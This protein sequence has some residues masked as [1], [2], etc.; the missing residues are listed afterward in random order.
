MAL[1]DYD[2]TR[3]HVGIGDAVDAKK[4]FLI[5]GDYREMLQNSPRV[6]SFGSQQ[7][8]FDA[9]SLSR[10]TQDDFLGGCYWPDWTAEDN[11]VF[12]S[13]LNMLPVGQGSGLR[14]VAPFVIYDDETGGTDPG[15]F[16]GALGYNELLIS[17]W[18]NRIVKTDVDTG[19]RTETSHASSHIAVGKSKIESGQLDKPVLWTPTSLAGNYY[20]QR[21][22][23]NAWSA[24]TQYAAPASSLACTGME[25]GGIVPVVAFGSI[26]SSMVLSVTD[27]TTPTFTVIDRMPGRWQASCSHNLM[28]MILCTD[29]DYKTFVVQSDGSTVQTLVEF[30][31]NFQGRAIASYGGRLYVLGVGFDFNGQESYVELWEVTGTSLRSIKTWAPERRLTNDPIPGVD[32]LPI[33]G[34]SMCVHEGLLFLG[35]ISKSLI[36]YDVVNDGLYSGPALQD[37]TQEAY[38]NSGSADSSIRFGYTSY[39]NNAS[40]WI[41][42]D[43][44]SVTDYVVQSGDYLEY[45][46]FWSPS[47]ATANKKLDF[48]LRCS[49]TTDSINIG[50]AWDDDEHSILAD[51]GDISAYAS[52]QWYHRTI[53]IPAGWVGKTIQKYY[54][55]GQLDTP[56]GSETAIAYFRAIEITDGAGT[57]RKTIYEAGDT[58][59]FAVFN[60]S[61]S[62]PTYVP[63]WSATVL[64]TSSVSHQ[65]SNLFTFRGRL[66]GYLIDPTSS[67][68]GYHYVARDSSEIDTSYDGELIT[69]DFGPEPGLDKRW[70]SIHLLTRYGDDDPTLEYSTDHGATWTSATLSHTSD[71]DNRTSIA[72][73]S[74]ASVSRSL[75]LK[76]TLPRGTNVDDYTELRAF[77][78]SFSFLE[79]GKRSWSMTINAASTIEDVGGETMYQDVSEIHDTI[80]DWAAGQTPLFFTDPDGEAYKCSLVNLQQ[81]MPRVGPQ[82]DGDI[83]EA[84][85]TVTLVEA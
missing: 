44:T 73:L 74:A 42:V 45:E 41:A 57:T 61:P 13:S 72:D 63:T 54:I 43:L 69:S 2:E 55:Q 18:A 66:M 51:E 5:E 79:S 16:Y 33:T 9:P 50:A 30:P 35:V 10:W 22:D 24:L 6:T 58:P 1:P 4:G 83:R 37:I 77:T 3:H 62:Y 80:W 19:T 53:P 31:V 65:V 8:L 20:F 38:V 59:T 64:N 12:A 46:V 47:G 27:A 36:A 60:G 17:T 15:Q 48:Q 71:G 78:L 81:R 39:P 26:L 75:R 76:I 85:F 52:N 40:S 49:D 56:S 82:V 34:D 70:S 28:A 67:V 25:F 32:D 21:K 7:E 11:G 29:G 14:T 68:Q 23:I 84:F